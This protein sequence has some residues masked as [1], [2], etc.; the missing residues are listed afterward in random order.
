LAYVPADALQAF[1]ASIAAAPQ[2]FDQ[3]TALMSESAPHDGKRSI[4]EVLQ[5]V[6]DKTSIDLRNEIIGALGAEVCIAQLH[7]GDGSRHSGVLLLNLKNEQAFA[8]ALEKM[9][10]HKKVAI[11]TRDYKGVSVRTL[12][13]EK[14]RGL[15]YAFMN[16]NLIASGDVTAVERVIDTAQKNAP[17]LASSERYVAASASLKSSPQFVYYNSNADYVS[18]LGSMLKSK[19]YEFKATGAQADIHPS[20]A[21]GLTQADGFYVE[22]RTP[23]GTFPR[24]LTAVTAQLARDKQVKPENAERQVQQEAK[25][26]VKSE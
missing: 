26:Q 25:P 13:G 9:A 15:S 21:F 16:G 7:A 24:L 17:S 8:Q 20:F 2:T 3:F 23:L 6:T 19:D 4:A 1:D 5:E 11:E 12:A 10:Q 18:R 22:S 14:E